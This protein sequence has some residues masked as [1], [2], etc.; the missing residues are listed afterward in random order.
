MTE[1]TYGN[2][3][4]VTEYQLSPN[5]VPSDVFDN[6]ESAAPTIVVVGAH[7]GVH[8][9]HYGLMKF[10][11]ELDDFKLYLIEPMKRFFD[12][13][14][15]V[16]DKFGDKVKYLN[17]AISEID[18]QVRMVDQG[19][20]SKLGNGNVTVRSKT[21]NSFIIENDI[22]EIDILLLDCEGYEFNILKQISDKKN[23]VKSIRYEYYWVG[24]KQGLDD[25]LVNN[26]YDV[27]LC[28]NDPTY[29]KVAFL[30]I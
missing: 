25:H 21:W 8:G 22:D 29:N 27:K 11:E 18:G 1:R 24:D 9:E 30:K 12:D 16:Y 10:L 14:P 28:C 4:I 17:Y 3:T 19:I 23:I 7:D 13:L 6:I 26:N 15:E 2:S 5:P 20:M